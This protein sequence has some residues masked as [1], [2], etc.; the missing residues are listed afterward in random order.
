M[1]I[2]AHG[3][4]YGTD[5]GVVF[6]MDVKVNSAFATNALDVAFVY[7][8]FHMFWFIPVNIDLYDRETQAR[9]ADRADVW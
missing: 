3:H 1:Q 9:P 5:V 2:A 8:L 7:N 6:E 4:M